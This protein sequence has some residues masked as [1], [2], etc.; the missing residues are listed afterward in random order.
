MQAAH[1]VDVVATGEAADHA[2]TL[3]TYDLAILDIGLPG[4]DAAAV[5][6]TSTVLVGRSAERIARAARDLGCDRIVFGSEPVRIASRVFGSLGPSRCATCWAPATPPSSAPERRRDAPGPRSK[7]RAAAQPSN[8]TTAGAV[9]STSSSNSLTPSQTICTPRH[10][11][12]KAARR[13]KTTVPA[14]PSGRS[15]YWA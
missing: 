13:R 14:S 11:R 2:L 10:S 15:R 9:A 12:M 5:P 7:G 8:D 1:A 6:Y 4:L 3:A